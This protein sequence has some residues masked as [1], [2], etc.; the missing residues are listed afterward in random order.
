MGPPVPVMGFPLPLPHELHGAITI[1]PKYKIWWVVMHQTHE[2]HLYSPFVPNHQSIPGTCT[3]RVNVNAS[4]WPSRSHDKPSIWRAPLF[5]SI[6]EQVITEIYWH[7]IILKEFL[8]ASMLPTYFHFLIWYR[9]YLAWHTQAFQVH[10]LEPTSF[11]HNQ[12]DV[13]N[14]I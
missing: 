6:L 3:Q 5:S 12:T 4:T 9:W 13:L 7:F 8:A 11:I 10:I 1:T 14:R 2:P